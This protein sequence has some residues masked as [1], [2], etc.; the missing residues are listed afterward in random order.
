M[1]WFCM[2]IAQIALDPSP[3]IQANV[4]KKVPQTILASH[5]NPLLTGNAHVE[6]TYFKKGLPYLV[7]IIPQLSFALAISSLNN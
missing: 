1:C 7:K 3:L 5:Y 6:T 4:G 2:G